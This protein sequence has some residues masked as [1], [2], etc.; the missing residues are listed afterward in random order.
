MKSCKGDDILYAIYR[1]PFI[2][3]VLRSYTQ[4]ERERESYQSHMQKVT[5]FVRTGHRLVVDIL[6]F[7]SLFLKSRPFLR[8][9]FD[10]VLFGWFIVRWQDRC[11]AFLMRGQPF[12]TTAQSYSVCIWVCYLFPFTQMPFF[13]IRNEKQHPTSIP[14]LSYTFLFCDIDSLIFSSLHRPP[15]PPPFPFWFCV[16]FIDIGVHVSKIKLS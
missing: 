4:R 9:I 1:L 15:S 13:L 8:I 12:S 10:L 2:H 7:F 14:C 3:F 11:S 16:R 5:L 6:K